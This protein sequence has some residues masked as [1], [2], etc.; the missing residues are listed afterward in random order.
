MGW[1]TGHPKTDLGGKKDLYPVPRGAA[2]PLEIPATFLD[3][4]SVLGVFWAP[5]SQMTPTHFYLINGFK[6]NYF[7]GGGSL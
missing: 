2:P 5:L 6:Q 7:F 4:R 1:S 3:L